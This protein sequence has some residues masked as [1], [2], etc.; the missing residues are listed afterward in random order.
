MAYASEQV[1]AKP[2]KRCGAE[3]RR[4]RIELAAERTPDVPTTYPQEDHICD[5]LQLELWDSARRQFGSRDFS[6]L[7]LIA[8]QIP[9]LDLEPFDQLLHPDEQHAGGVAVD[10]LPPS[11][12]T[13]AAVKGGAT[14]FAV[15]LYA[16]ALERWEL[17]IGHTAIRELLTAAREAAQPTLQDANLTDPDRT[18]LPLVLDLA[19]SLS[20]CMAVENA[21][22]CSC[23]TDMARHAR[24]AVRAA[25]RVRAGLAAGGLERLPCGRY[26]Q[27]AAEVQQAYFQTVVNLASAVEQFIGDRLASRAEL[28]AVI[29]TMEQTE[30]ADEL[31]G[32]VYESELRAHRLTLQTMLELV[33]AGSIQVDEARVVYC[34][35]FTLPDLDPDAVLAA[36]AAW[37]AEVE[38]GATQVIDIQS[39]ALSDHWEGR[40]P[41][42]RRYGGLT[43]R[44]ADIGVTTTE[45]AALPAHRAEIRLSRLGN[46]YLRVSAPLIG[47][48]PHTLNQALRRGRPQMG[49]EKLGPPAPGGGAAEVRWTR[50]VDYA[51]EVVDALGRRLGYLAPVPE[52]RQLAGTPSDVRLAA[53]LDMDNRQ[54][55]VLSIRALAVQDAAGRSTPVHDY[56]QAVGAIGW[57]QLLHPVGLASSTLEE[58]LRYR[59]SAMSVPIDVGFRGETIIQTPELT[60]LIM[61]TSPNFMILSVEQIAEFAGTVPALLDEWTNVVYQQRAELARRISPIEP[62]GPRAAS[63]RISAE[64]AQELSR[65]ERRQL[66]LQDVVTRA[67]SLLAFLVSP[68]LVRTTRNRQLLDGLLAGGGFD[69]LRADLDA[70]IAEVDDLYQ[71]VAT[72]LRQLEERRQQQYRVVVELALVLLAVLSLADFLTLFNGAFS[73]RHGVLQVESLAVLALAAVVG[74]VSWRAG[75]RRSN[76]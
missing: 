63:K 55:T 74:V 76:E 46:H 11:F 20:D 10:H 16:L 49:A 40:D 22:N 6:A 19:S 71:R 64:A 26:L 5:L 31:R 73:V 67:R 68:G 25:D 13:A 51:T 47:V 56:Q 54:H 12:Q 8:G 9:G 75:R 42:G 53:R 35:P 44:L 65:L 48:S 3:A 23:P 60:T 29:R 4:G 24:T 36:V 59:S 58:Y 33:E 2:R 17:S 52:H 62:T 15:Y 41:A 21:L 45:P 30:S 14:V 38:L 32:D 61:P 50:L 66:H 72:L 37:P 18:L 43:L 57:T 7:R 69:R 1:R 28:A 70:Q 27:R 34:Y 39:T